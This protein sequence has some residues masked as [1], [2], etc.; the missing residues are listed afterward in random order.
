MAMQARAFTRWGG[1]AL[2]AYL[3]IACGAPPPK[4]PTKAETKPAP[5]EPR[6]VHERITPHVCSAKSKLAELLGN[7]TTPPD[8]AADQQAPE[9]APPPTSTAGAT[10]VAAN[11]AYRT[12]APSTVLIR[13]DHGMGTGVVIDPKGYVLTNYGAASSPRLRPNTFESGGTEVVIQT[14]PPTTERAPITVS[15]PRIVAPA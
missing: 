12:V 11:Q 13:T 8:A 2:V 6:E 10:K 7:T 15:P 3:A 5:A 9:S 4:A 14:L 1:A